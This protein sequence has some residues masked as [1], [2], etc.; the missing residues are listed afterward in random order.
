MLNSV[1]ITIIE[2]SIKLVFSIPIFGFSYIFDY[3]RKSYKEGSF[4]KIFA[5]GGLLKIKSRNGSKNDINF[6]PKL[7]ERITNLK[8]VSDGEGRIMACMKQ[9]L[10]LISKGHNTQL[11][12]IDITKYPIF[13]QPLLARLNPNLVLNE[14]FIKHYGIPFFDVKTSKFSSSRTGEEI[15]TSLII[16]CTNKE[17]FDDIAFLNNGDGKTQLLKILSDPYLNRETFVKDYPTQEHWNFKFPHL[18]IDNFNEFRFTKELTLQT[19]NNYAPECHTKCVDDPKVDIIKTTY[20]R[21]TNPISLNLEQAKIND[22][23]IKLY[24][25]KFI[26]NMI[27]SNKTI[28]DKNDLLTISDRIL[29]SSKRYSRTLGDCKKSKSQLENIEMLL[30]LSAYK[31]D[32]AK[33]LI[34][35]FNT[36]SDTIPNDK[37]PKSNFILPEKDIEWLDITESQNLIKKINQFFNNGVF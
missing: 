2:R 9:P 23:G 31:L 12:S 33:Q 16:E 34:S 13:T 29:K 24:Q 5:V 8:N 11:Q 20:L 4:S 35:Y 18:I 22:P 3:I 30:N 17:V 15:P 6:N 26:P 19:G 7:D 21:E 28:L 25:I 36:F 10:T 14:N 1:N 27:S 37:L 32:Q